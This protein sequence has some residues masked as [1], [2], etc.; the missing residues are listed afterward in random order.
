MKRIVISGYYGFGNIGDEAVLA[1]IIAS[2]RTIQDDVELLVL[3]G[4]PAHTS[5]TH[6]VQAINRCAISAVISA[7]R[8]ADLLI[9]GGGSLLQD[10]TSARSA[11]YYFGLMLIAELCRAPFMIYAQGIGPITRSVTKLQMRTL[12][13]RARLISVRDEDSANLLLLLGV[14]KPPIY[15][16]ADPSFAL[17][18]AEDDEARRI[19]GEAQVPEGKPLLGVAVR[20]WSVSESWPDVL[21]RG[22]SDAAA[23]LGATPVFIPMHQ[24]GDVALS[25]NI[26]KRLT[27]PSVIL[28][29]QLTPSQAK[30]IV[31]Q[32]DVMLAMRLHALMFAAAQ[33]TPAVAMTYDPKVTA[34]ANSFSENMPVIDA[35]ETTADEITRTII[36]AWANRED[37][38]SAL[39]A[40]LP[41][42]RRKAVRNTCL[43]LSLLNSKGTIT[44]LDESDYHGL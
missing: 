36:D 40:K 19:L 28:R 38:R 27:V 42:L 3:S 21:A 18:P 20:H 39:Y 10:I 29:T 16:T 31:G 1:G 17:E 12:L 15:V 30:A 14:K 32:M 11:A 23:Q 25:E 43:A 7:I 44:E 8:D 5:A 37:I 9:S 26:T 6:G 4:D 41:E 13:N 34:F 24:P 2:F 22:I 33:G 35:R